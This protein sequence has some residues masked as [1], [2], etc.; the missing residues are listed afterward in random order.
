[1]AKKYHQK[2][3]KE[4]FDDELLR[5]CMEEHDI[6]RV[7][8]I[9][10]TRCNKTNAHPVLLDVKARGKAVLFEHVKTKK[11]KE[12]V[13]QCAGKKGE[14]AVQSSI[15]KFYNINKN[16]SHTEWFVYT[17]YCAN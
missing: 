11:H 6:C 17:I 13:D 3:K 9:I 14:G 5:D 12:N 10:C 8:C 15:D 7:K 1:M 2:V 16:V 4:W